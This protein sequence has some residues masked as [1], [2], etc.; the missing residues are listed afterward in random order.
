ML[1]IPCGLT[2][3]KGSGQGGHS[4]AGSSQPRQPLASLALEEP[5]GFLGS[6]AAAGAA[7]L[8]HYSGHTTHGQ[9]L[10]ELP[11]RSIKVQHPRA[12]GTLWPSWRPD[13]GHSWATPHHVLG[14]SLPPPREPSPSG[15]SSE[16]R[17]APGGHS[18]EGH[19]VLLQQASQQYR[20]LSPPCGCV[21]GG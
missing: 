12:W 4:H 16:A 19:L 21:S 17:P 10:R 18:G 5:G 15:T 7:L 2:W 6:Q 9:A 3:P 8:D 11:H 1:Q 20:K 13:P 14:S